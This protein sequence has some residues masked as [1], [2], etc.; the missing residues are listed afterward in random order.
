[1]FSRSSSRGVLDQVAFS[2]TPYPR[3]HLQ[4]RFR[5]SVKRLHATPFCSR[6]LIQRNMSMHALRVL[7]LGCVV[8]A[9][10]AFAPA[11]PGSAGLSARAA[12]AS[13]RACGPAP[14]LRTAWPRRQACAA[15]RGGAVAGRGRYMPL[16]RM[17]ASEDDEGG[18]ASLP[19]IASVEFYGDELETSEAVSA[20]SLG[21][22]IRK[23]S[24]SCSHNTALLQ[25]LQGVWVLGFRV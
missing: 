15:V 13:G 5:L 14:C 23:T 16:V 19:S 24:V 2:S 4:H 3:L 12:M 8:R 11:A 7:V 6:F 17:A 1:M 25:L 9:A 22:C 21:R 10:E 18:S 20:R